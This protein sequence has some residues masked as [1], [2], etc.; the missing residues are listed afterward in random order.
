MNNPFDRKKWTSSLQSGDLRLCESMLEGRGPALSLEDFDTLQGEALSLFIRHTVEGGPMLEPLL[1]LQRVLLEKE[2]HFGYRRFWRDLDQWLQLRDQNNQWRRIVARL[3]LGRA[4]GADQWQEITD[5]LRK[6]IEDPQEPRL[7]V[8]SR[9]LESSWYPIKTILDQHAVE[10]VF[11]NEAQELGVHDFSYRYLQGHDAAAHASIDD[12]FGFSEH[13]E[14]LDQQPPQDP[15]PM[16]RTP[17]LDV[18]EGPVPPN[19]LFAVRVYSDKAM[20]RPGEESTEM[21]IDLPGALQEAEVDTWLS[22]SSHFEIEGANTGSLTVRRS[23]VR[24]AN[25]LI[26]KLRVKADQTGLENNIGRITVLFSFQG[27]PA[28]RV[29]REVRIETGVSQSS[30]SAEPAPATAPKPSLVVGARRRPDLEVRITPHPDQLPW[31]FE[32]TVSGPNTLTSTATWQ[33]PTQTNPA[34]FVARS[35][36]MFCARNISS[37]QRA[38]ML[39]GA[40]REFFKA[41]PENFKGAY[42][43]LVDEGRPPRTIAI[44]SEEPTFPWELI[45]PQRRRQDSSTQTDKP[46]GVQSAIGRWVHS[47]CV[48]PPQECT[49]TDSYV[50]VPTYPNPLQHAAQEGEMVRSNFQ[51]TL[52]APATYEQLTGALGARSVSLV[53]FACHGRTD[54]AKGQFIVLDNREELYA[55][56]ASGSAQFL[57]GFS[58]Q[59]LV[60]LNACEAG[61]QEISLSGPQGF[62]PVF[63]DLGATAVIA[64]IWSVED[65]VAGK[66]AQTLYE[67]I[68]QGGDVLLA[69]ELQ[70][71]RELAYSVPAG[72]TN[73]ATDSYAAYCF[74]GDP[75]LVVRKRNSS[76]D[77]A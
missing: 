47:N 40:G 35:L 28:G 63:T 11:L 14:P 32:C 31:K 50:V 4:R 71:L 20:P 43:R 2:R 17:H 8:Q 13:M 39:L 16:R 72:Q 22:C 51:G 70:R 66:I 53:H 5:S 55:V 29:T 25:D 76:G 65:K 68:M 73:S 60:F 3:L 48:P 10:N 49:L 19:T 36:D 56:S 75:L 61:R 41:A 69:T 45:V 54:P 30:Q 77:R 15:T 1:G 18:P 46:L 34:A 6:T 74:Y 12:V 9:T 58:A 67:R 42:W 38:D 24:S 44:Y 26:F 57:K 27:A 52:I 23:E 7:H 64:A 21:V 62:A 59:P 37:A 33:L